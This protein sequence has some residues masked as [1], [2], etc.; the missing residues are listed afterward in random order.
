MNLI[1]NLVGNKAKI[2][3]ACYSAIRCAEDN[4]IEAAI[5]KI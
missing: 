4:L 3:E 5:Y 1:H 2:L